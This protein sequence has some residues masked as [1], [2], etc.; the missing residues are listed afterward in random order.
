[1]SASERLCGTRTYVGLQVCR[2]S[3]RAGA[4]TN[5][6]SHYPDVLILGGGVIGLTTAY[7]LAREGGSVDLIDK[8]DF[9]QE[10]SWAGAG[11]IPPGNTGSARH[12]YDQL[13]A[14]SA[15]M[16]PELSAELR[17]ATGIDNGYRVSGGL[18]WLDEDDLDVL[19]AWNQEGLRVQKQ[20]ALTQ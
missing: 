19:E 18:E 20:T 5:L 7:F 2:L 14:Q 6:M 1:D 12:P 13:R 11:I 9:G 10:P 8:S 17:Q 4:I 15:V 3:A 16:F